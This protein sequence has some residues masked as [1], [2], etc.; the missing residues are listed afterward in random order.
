MCV[1][2][3]VS[4]SESLYLELNFFMMSMQAYMCALYFFFSIIKSRSSGTKS[5]IK[6]VQGKV[7]E[8]RLKKK[9]L[10]VSRFYFMLSI[11]IN[12]F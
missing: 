9:T 10:F 3:S 4:V 5:R 2:V 11:N 8:T 6:E 7:K 12:I 1:R